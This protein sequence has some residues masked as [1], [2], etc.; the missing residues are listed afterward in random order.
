MRYDFGFHSKRSCFTRS[1]SLA[2]SFTIG[3]AVTRE[4]KVFFTNLASENVIVGISNPTRVIC[5]S[6][7][8]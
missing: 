1:S 8:S 6:I 7:R 2:T 3:M 5:F 4:L